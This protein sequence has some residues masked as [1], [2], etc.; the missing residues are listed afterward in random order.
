MIELEG[1]YALPLN[2][3]YADFDKNSRELANIDVTELKVSIK[4]GGQDQPGT[5][6]LAT[7][8]QQAATGCKYILVNGFRRY[9]ACKEA[10]IPTYKATVKPSMSEDEWVAANFREN[11]SRQALSFYEESKAL[12]HFVKKGYSEQDI[13]STLGKSRSWVQP[14]VMLAKMVLRG[15]TKINDIAR[16]MNFDYALVRTLNSISDPADLNDKLDEILLQLE[17]GIKKPKVTKTDVKTKQNVATML[18][19][20]TKPMRAALTEWAFGKQVPYEG[21]SKVIAW[22]NGVINDYDLMDW[23]DELIHDPRQDSELK[24]IFDDLESYKENTQLLYAKL[25]AI[26]ENAAER[27]Y[28]RPVN[29]FPQK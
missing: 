4:N 22:T 1:I 15:H 26:K 14:R 18:M 23:F 28:E 29:G 2:E 3:I 10:G 7:A 12:M 27:T 17:H 6:C 9:K 25:A 20:R 11:D 16:K 5:V 24:D 13:M 21:W 8:E 19:E